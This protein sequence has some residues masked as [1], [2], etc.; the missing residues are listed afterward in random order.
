MLNPVLNECMLN[1]VLNVTHRRRALA[2]SSGVTALPKEA[3]AEVR[4]L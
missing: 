2:L 4:T 3:D 1:S